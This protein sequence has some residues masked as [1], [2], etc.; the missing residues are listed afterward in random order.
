MPC[1]SIRLK[2]IG[3]YMNKYFVK[4][5]STKYFENVSEVQSST[6][7]VTFMVHKGEGQS[8]ENTKAAVFCICLHV[9][10]IYE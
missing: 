2:S 8:E 4:N 3:K 5:S 7:N 9:C 10:G 6:A 1:P